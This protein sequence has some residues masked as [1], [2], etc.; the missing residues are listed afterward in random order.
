MNEP[1]TEERQDQAEP[2]GFEF[3][4]QKLE[5]TVLRLEEGNLPLEESLRLYEEGIE[6]YRRCQ[7]KLRKADVKVRKLVEALDGRLEEEPFEMPGRETSSAPAETEA[8][9]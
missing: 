7:E 2:A 8:H 4:L 9:E 1:Q 5:R 3:D 6:A